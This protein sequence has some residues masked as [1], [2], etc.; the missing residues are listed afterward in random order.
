[1]LNRK[2]L[3]VLSRLTAADHKG[4]RLFLQAGYFNHGYNAAKVFQLYEY[5]MKHQADHEHPAL[6]K[7][8]VSAVFFQDKAFSENG[9][10]PI[11]T[12]ASDLFRL[13]RRYLHQVEWE[14]TGTEAE[15]MLT[16][17]RFYRRHGLEERFKPLVGSI[18]KSQESQAERDAHFYFSQFLLEE[19]VANFKST[20]TSNEDD[21]NLLAVHQ[22]LDTLFSIYKLEALCSSAY[23]S[24]TS[25]VNSLPDSPLTRFMVELVGRHSFA[26]V[27]LAR[28][29]QLVY[30]LIHDPGR[31]DFLLELEEI[32]TNHASTF[33]PDKYFNLQALYRALWALRHRQGGGADFTMKL[34]ELYADHQAK[35]YFEIDGRISPSSM[36]A[37]TWLGLRAKQYDWVKNFLDNHPPQRL[38]GTRFLQEAYNR[39]YAEYYFA[40]G[41]FEQAKNYL[42]YQPFENV[43]YS[44]WAD[45]LLIQI[46]F[47]TEDELLEP[48]MTALDR[49]IRRSGISQENKTFYL[50]FLRK[51]SK[52]IRYGWEKNSPKRAALR[53]E[54]ER[55]ANIASREWLLEK[56]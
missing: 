54:I 43:T 29:Y 37:L 14:Q 55:T 11:D 56:L 34:F 28:A 25:A 31:E 7:A 35:G 5:V 30:L 24:I 46:Y 22:N 15:E 21:F 45:L 44:I 10:G 19:E 40:L 4:L 32:L 51:L 49:K 41:N 42:S 20:F 50:N 36:R 48:R 53:Q 27:P 18:R 1:M 8:V 2:L 23:Q 6:D 9:K 16:L 17:A 38:S 52:I 26:D 12:L 33:P 13:V 47:E 3:E 39:N